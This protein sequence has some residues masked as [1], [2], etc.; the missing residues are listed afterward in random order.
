MGG[1]KTWAI[2]SISDLH[3]GVGPNPVG[4]GGNFPEWWSAPGCDKK[5]VGM[6]D[7]RYTFYTDN[8]KF[9]MVTNGNVYI[10][11]HQVPNFPGAYQNLTDFTA[12]FAD[13]LNET[14]QIIEEQGSYFIEVSGESFIGYYSGVHKYQ[15]V[16]IS[17]NRLMLKF[18]DN[19]VSD[20]AWYIKLVPENTITGVC[21]S[22]GNNGNSFL[23]VDF[24]TTNFDVFFFGGSTAERISNP[25]KTGINTSSYVL[26]TGHGYEIWAG[27][28]LHF[29]SNIDFSNAKTISLKL[30]ASKP[31]EFR[32]T[33]KSSNPS[34]TL[35]L[36]RYVNYYKTNEW[37]TISFSFSEAWSNYF[38]EI[39]LNPGWLDPNSGTF[40]IDDVDLN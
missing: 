31:G 26:K 28:G 39:V 22:S 15:I 33:L 18:L 12:P 3:F 20:R 24:E 5:G 6:Y 9:D 38:N 1:A 21:S 34:D 35:E 16:E 27:V 36:D 7:D 23:P 4:S 30:F 25:H 13:H 40:Y 17:E 8:S 11:E 19:M 10:N 2:D 32:F 29:P 37:Q 14:W